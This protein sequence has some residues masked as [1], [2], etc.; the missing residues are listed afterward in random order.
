MIST[1]VRKLRDEGFHY[2]AF[3]YGQ[4]CLACATDFDLVGELT[5]SAEGSCYNCG[6]DDLESQR[7]TT[8]RREM[9]EG[10]EVEVYAASGNVRPY[11]ARCYKYGKLVGVGGFSK[12]RQGAIRAALRSAKT[13]PTQ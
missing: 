8:P 2:V 5:F 13:R 9:V 11:Q 4:L 3:D 12:S 10:Y 6:E 1:E 7:R